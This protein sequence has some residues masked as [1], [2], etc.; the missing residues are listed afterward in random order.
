MNRK[1]W[2]W[3]VA[4]PWLA[5]P[6][7]ALRFWLAWDQ[8]PVRMATHFDASGRPNG[9]MTRAAAMDF[10]LVLTAVMLLVFTVIAYIAHKRSEGD[11][12][13]WAVLG[14]LY[15][16]LGIIYYGN[17]SVLEYNLH[18]RSVT[19][20]PILIILPVAIV[21]FI[22]IYLG[23]NRGGQLPSA[24]AIAEEEHGSR[25]WALIFLVLLGVELCVAATVPL[26]GVRAGMALL[27][28][29][30]AICAAFTWSGFQYRF[31]YAGLEIR[32]LGFR[33][34]SI[35]ASHIQQY[36]PGTWSVL[37]GYG[38]RGIG[39]CRAYV[40]GNKG[41][42]ISTTD[43]QIFLGHDDPARIVRDL[44]LIKATR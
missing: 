10:V 40:W 24:P 23:V 21:V 38:I 6:A 43:G 32:T 33:L 41:V 44:D 35:P 4:L 37:R 22:A 39:R 26:P 36:A 25:A 15:V 42:Q 2:P 9:W 31:S 17:S 14:L 30:F 28:L 3:L 8:L 19:V 11:A 13:S 5:L 7:I 1:L 29:V 34:R 27:A 18:A 16:I 20:T 12:I